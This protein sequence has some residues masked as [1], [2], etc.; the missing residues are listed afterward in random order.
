MLGLGGGEDRVLTVK[1]LLVHSAECLPGTC[2]ALCWAVGEGMESSG[3]PRLPGMQ[4]TARESSGRWDHC[5]TQER[6][7]AKGHV[8]ASQRQKDRER[9]RKGHGIRY[10]DR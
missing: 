3:S 6:R 9:A 4:R 8:E 7:G 2:S 10:R 1:S 5:L